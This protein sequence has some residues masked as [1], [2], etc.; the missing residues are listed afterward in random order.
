MSEVQDAEVEGLVGWRES[1]ER[2]GPKRSKC[3]VC[4]EEMDHAGGRPQKHMELKHGAAPLTEPQTQDDVEGAEPPDPKDVR[5]KVLEMMHEIAE[6][7][8]MPANARVAAGRL[9]SDIERLQEL[10][11]EEDED[12]AEG[13]VVERY[14]KALLKKEDLEEEFRAGLR[15]LAV[16]ERVERLCREARAAL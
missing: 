12:E 6:G 15:D 13:R 5:S 3:K 16:L 1:F 11:V 14:R 2:V 10:D 9:I 7:D 4:G 8:E